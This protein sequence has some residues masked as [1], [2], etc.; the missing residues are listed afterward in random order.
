MG[1]AAHVQ[2]MKMATVRPLDAYRHYGVYAAA[3]TLGMTAT[4][5]GA[6]ADRFGGKRISV[7]ADLS[8]GAS[9]ALVP[10]L[11]GAGASDLSF[12][13]PKRG[14]VACPPAESTPPRARMATIGAM[15]FQVMASLQ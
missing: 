10:L 8:S 6:L 9:V 7:L 5:G 15:R 11:C 2:E 13:C 4:V 12:H 3:V 1:W 14:L